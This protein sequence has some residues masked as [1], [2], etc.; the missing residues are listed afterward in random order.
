M[1]LSLYDIS[2]PLFVS[3]LKNL[4]VLLDKALASGIP[5]ADLLEARLAPD[6]RPLP[7]QV[8]LASD[9]A[10][11]ATA[12]LAGVE[13][14][15]MPD[16]ETTFAELKERIAKT[17]AFIESVDPARFDGGVDRDIT[18]ALPTFALKWKGADYLRQFA[19]PNFYFHVTVLYAILRAKGVTIGKQDY[20]TIDPSAVH[21]KG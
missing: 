10:K 18:V 3:G 8:Q 19:L 13:N 6:M 7:Q 16:T 9:T 11:G 17:V 12:R 21:P 14:P 1:S 2:V 20:L 5:E 15:S 4:S